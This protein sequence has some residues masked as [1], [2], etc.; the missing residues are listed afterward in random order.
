MDGQLLDGKKL[1][2]ARLWF[3]NDNLSTLAFES[4]ALGVATG[5]EPYS[6]TSRSVL[7]DYARQYAAY[8]PDPDFEFSGRACFHAL[9]EA[10]WLIELSWACDLAWRNAADPDA[11]FVRARL[12]EPAAEWI[13]GRRRRRVHNIECWLNVAVVTAGLACGRL[14]LV[15]AGLEG[16][17]GFREQIRR[18]VLVDGL[19]YEGSLSYHFYAL[20][21]LMWTSRPCAAV[22]P[23]LSRPRAI[24]RMLLAPIEL[25]AADGSLPSSNDCWSPIN[26][27]S[28]CGHGILEPSDF[29]ETGWAWYRRS[30]FA[31]ALHRA[32]RRRPRDSMWVLLEGRPTLPE[33]GAPD[34]QPSVAFQDSGLAY[35][36]GGSFG[37]FLKFGRHGG[38][39][40]HYDKLGLSVY[41]EDKDFSVDL[42][43]PG[44]GV[45]LS[46]RWYAHTASHNTVIVDGNRQ[47]PGW[48]SL[49]RFETAGAFQ[50]ADAAVAWTKRPYDGVRFRRA[51]VL[52]LP[53]LIDLFSVAA[54]DPRQFD[55]IYHNSGS[56]RVPGVP[57]LGDRAGG[58]PPHPDLTAWAPLRGARAV[59]W[60][61]RDEAG[62]TV[63][64]GDADVSE[65]YSGVGP[66][67]PASES[68]TAIIRRLHGDRGLFAAVFCP[69]RGS[70]PVYDVDLELDTENGVRRLTVE[71]DDRRDIW[72]FGSLDGNAGLEVSLSR[73]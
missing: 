70:C 34:I 43:T 41:G 20:A 55:W 61:D 33:R 58:T 4:A 13:A 44:F 40:G 17:Y 8:E 63:F 72:E 7:A 9:D 29:Y 5:H 51:I 53:Y 26:L 16:A 68:R 30:E 22:R 15:D 69:W 18:G 49:L 6:E 25:S 71:L 52:G 56:F 12:L 64:L 59:E 65:L 28:R 3:V 38:V 62:L 24:E 14:D 10:V 32:Y 23:D 31:A 21:A 73:D 60:T 42:G 11:G 1:D 66:S 67:N 46:D 19:W 50:L 57:T 45:R 54:P 36:R 39:H 37:L 35:L 47:P 27:T 48:G 2:A